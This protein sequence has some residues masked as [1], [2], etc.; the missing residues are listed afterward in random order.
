METRD[1][2]LSK[3]KIA[4]T[5][6]HKTLDDSQTVENHDE[7]EENVSFHSGTPA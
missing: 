7:L 3:T 4:E 5:D 6:T 1:P 2:A